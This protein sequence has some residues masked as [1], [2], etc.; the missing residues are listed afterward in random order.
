MAMFFCALTLM[1]ARAQTRADDGTGYM[2]GSG[3]REIDSGVVKEVLKSDLIM[4]DN[5]RR[6]RLDNVRT[7]PYI[8]SSAMEELRRVFQGRPVKVY[9]YHDSETMFDRY[10]VP[11]A[12]VIAND[13]STWVQDYLVGKGLAW[14]SSTETSTQMIGLLK[15]TEEKARKSAAGFWAD[16]DYA[17]KTPDNVGRY[18]DSY[19]IVQGKILSV[20]VNNG[21]VFFNFGL[22]WKTDFTLRIPENFAM[23]MGRTYMDETTLA[24]ETN[25]NNWKGRVIRVRGWVSENN[26]PMMTLTHREQLDLIKDV[27]KDAETIKSEQDAAAAARQQQQGQQNP[28]GGGAGIP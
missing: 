11:L 18:E 26:G 13:G 23:V 27:P 14:A 19:Q 6:Y 24:R 8:E 3:M 20:A 17:I 9:T 5:N 12:H 21:G 4:L 25:P 22:D 16:P 10:G 1:Q 28:A 2:I 7:P 15:R